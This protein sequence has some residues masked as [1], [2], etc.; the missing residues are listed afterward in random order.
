MPAAAAAALAM[1]EFL[2][3]SYDAGHV[4]L[5]PRRPLIVMTIVIAPGP[6]APGEEE[7][8]VL[9]ALLDSPPP[10]R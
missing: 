3:G 4:E 8:T 7:V 2:Q 6:W 9:R 10:Y 1:D 5:Q